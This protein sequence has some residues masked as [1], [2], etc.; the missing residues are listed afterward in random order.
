MSW[1]E[2]AMQS[3]DSFLLYLVLCVRCDGDLRKHETELQASLEPQS[4][5]FN[6]GTV[7]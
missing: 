1:V 7:K 2:I 6:K 4:S 5:Y 3:F